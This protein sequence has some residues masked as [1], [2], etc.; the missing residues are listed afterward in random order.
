[1]YRG[2]IQHKTFVTTFLRTQILERELD[3]PLGLGRI[4]RIV[5]TDR[6]VRRESIALETGDDWLSGLGHPNGWVRDTAQQYL[7]AESA[8]ARRSALERLATS[9]P[10]ATTRL[11]ALWTLA[12][13][14]PAAVS[15]EL[16]ERLL[17]DA[18]PRVR[19]AALQTLPS[20]GTM[21]DVQRQRIV[22]L[23]VTASDSEAAAES[24]QALLTLG[25]LRA[26]PAAREALSQAFLHQ[27]DDPWIPQA[28]LSG[29]QGH[30]TDLLASALS[31]E[32]C[33]AS[34][35][36]RSAI[37]ELAAAAVRSGLA[38]DRLVRAFS[39][40]LSAGGERARLAGE[41]LSAL[42][43]SDVRARTLDQELASRPAKV[44]FRQLRRALRRSDLE[45]ELSD[46]LQQRLV[47]APELEGVLVPGQPS[48]PNAP[49][50][51]A[52]CEACHGGRGQGQAGLAPPLIDSPYVLGDPE[53]LVRIVLDGVTGPIIVHGEQWDDSM[54][55]FRGE[56]TFTDEA[57]AELL[58]YIR[59]AWSHRASDVTA[60]TVEAIRQRTAV[61]QEAWTAEE[62]EAIGEDR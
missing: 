35:S 2:I 21:S 10:E 12:G 8:P 39:D 17:G 22:E 7:V 26:E 57:I 41:V 37:G 30:E 31:G 40:S 19:I 23:V 11:H 51:F 1:M 53:R 9:A 47:P 32:A 5:R 13:Y 25:D 28:V 58:S 6:P 44:A 38:S 60:R 14:R 27:L 61:R 59:S 48:D 62:L 52:T 4:Y 3:E 42:A 55:G 34:D 16:S 24:Y 20:P 29:M 15:A 56:E 18:D 49:A 45:V 43:D 50:L 54:P 33:S 46:Q 36:C